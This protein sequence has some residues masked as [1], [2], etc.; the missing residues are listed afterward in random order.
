M[1]IFD[2]LF[3]RS[4]SDYFDMFNFS[5]HVSTNLVLPM[6][7][8]RRFL[9]LVQI[10]IHQYCPTAFHEGS[11]HVYEN[12]VFAFLYHIMQSIFPK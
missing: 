8:G 4:S 7:Q 10:L 11:L 1:Q 12:G 9:V 2:F 6:Y 3:E 5:C